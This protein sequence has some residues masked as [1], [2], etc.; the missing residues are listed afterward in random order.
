MF[1]GRIAVILDILRSLLVIRNRFIIASPNNNCIEPENII[2]QMGN[3]KN[4]LK[5][6]TIYRSGTLKLNYAN[7]ATETPT[8]CSH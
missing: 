7:G 8:E 4:E 5:I 3:R 2:C 1:R 6:N